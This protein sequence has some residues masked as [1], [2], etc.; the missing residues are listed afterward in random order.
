MLPPAENAVPAPVRMTRRTDAS[1]VILSQASTN[2]VICAVSDRFVLQG[3]GGKLSDVVWGAI[4]FHLLMFVL[5][6]MLVA[7]PQIAL[8]LPQHMIGK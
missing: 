5:L 2:S 8:W 3:L 7:W 4:P 6:G 1:R